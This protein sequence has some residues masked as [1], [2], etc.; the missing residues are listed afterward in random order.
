MILYHGINKKDI[1]SIV[2][3]G[4]NSG[5]YWGALE[6]A[7]KYTDCASVISIDTET[8][9]LS[10]LPN[11]TI[12]EHYRD[13]DDELYS[14]WVMSKQTWEDSMKLFNS[15]IIEEKIMVDYDDIK[16]MS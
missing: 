5:S 7:M 16:K 9:E 2:E 3:D 15:V 4:L 6:E 8:C 12:I 1:E 11:Y 10:I 14:E 13:K